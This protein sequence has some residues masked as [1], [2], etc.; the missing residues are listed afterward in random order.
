ML[1]A[2]GLLTA[3]GCHPGPVIGAGPKPPADGTIAGIVSTD[4]KAPVPGRKVTAI[5]TATGARFEATTGVNGG[6]TMK[7]PQGAYRI[8]IELLPGEK[9]AKQPGQTRVNRSDLDPNRDFVI[10][11]GRPGG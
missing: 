6:Y 11:S 8:D 3:A 5:N 2:M 7:V 4:G 9:L 1:L 10:T